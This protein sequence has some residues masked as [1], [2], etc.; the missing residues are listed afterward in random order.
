ME[1]YSMTE[2]TKSSTLIVL[3][4][5]AVLGI[6]ASGLVGYN[7]GKNSAPTPKY[8]DE[9]V[10][11]ESRWPDSH[12]CVSATKDDVNSAMAKWAD[13]VISSTP[14]CEVTAGDLVVR[15]LAAYVQNDEGKAVLQLK[16]KEVIITEYLATNPAPRG[17]PTNTQPGAAPDDR[18]LIRKGAGGIGGL[19]RRLW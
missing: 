11:P 5:V 14:E 8:P 9:H 10:C 19:L 7:A 15:G 4:V 2:E 18:G 1:E 6:S 12:Q 13:A 3:S 17:N 16:D